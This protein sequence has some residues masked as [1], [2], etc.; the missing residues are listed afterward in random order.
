MCIICAKLHL[1]D[2]SLLNM[3]TTLELP[4]HLIRDVM[5]ISNHKTKTGAIISALENFVRSKKLHQLK[6]FKG[7]IDIA[8]DLDTLRKRQ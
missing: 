5:S 7:K 6:D 8:I 2:A 4:E 1:L 3:R